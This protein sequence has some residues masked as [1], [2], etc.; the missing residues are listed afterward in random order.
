MLMLF[1]EK[2]RGVPAGTTLVTHTV[3]FL[4]W[5]NNTQGTSTP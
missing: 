4:V 1:L 5:E 2:A 3:K